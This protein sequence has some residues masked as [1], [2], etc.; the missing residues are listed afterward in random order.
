MREWGRGKQRGLWGAAP[1]P[2][3]ARAPP[4]CTPA[5][6][7]APHRLTKTGGA[8][9]AGSARQYQRT[10]AEWLQA[11]AARGLGCRV[12]SVGYP[13]APEHKFPEARCGRARGA[14]RGRGLELAGVPPAC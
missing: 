11:L 6:S 9:C 3:R 1:L 10:Y 13:L 14:A 4:S 5:E 12:L 2:A 8:F 7:T